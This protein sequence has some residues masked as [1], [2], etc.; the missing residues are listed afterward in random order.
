MRIHWLRRLAPALTA[1]V[2]AAQAQTSPPPQRAASAPAT[3]ASAVQRI[4][5]TGGR[6]GDEEQ[7]RR[8]TAA[9]IVIGRDEIERMGDSNTLE[10]L[11]RL[12][13]ITIP[14]A[15]GRGGSP[16][17][18]GMGGGFTQIL[19]DGERVPP[20]FSLDSIPPEQIERIE[21]LRAPT[22]ETGA[23]A[24]AGTINIVLREGYR[25][26]LNDINVGVQWE[27]GERTPGGSWTRNDAVGDW[28]VNT[29]L[30]LF[31]PQRINESR[32]TRTDIDEAGDQ[33]V[34]ARQS[35]FRSD[36]SRKGLHANAR[37]QWR[38]DAGSSFLL[39]PMV[40]ANEGRTHGVGTVTQSIGSRP[41]EFARSDTTTDGRFTLGRLNLNYNH[42]VGALRLEWRAGVSQGR[43]RG[44]QQRLEFDGQGTLSRT[45]DE[46]TRSSDRNATAGLKA[47]ALL[48]DGHQAVG[49]L[50]VEDNR[51]SD[52]KTTLYD[53]VPQLSEFGAN[54]GARARRW[55]VYAQDEWSINPQW[56]V[57]AGLR[58]EGIRTEG[59]GAQGVV[60]RNTSRVATPLLHAVW[61]PD[62]TKRD[63]VRASLTRSYRAPNTGQL[64]G[65]P[66][67]NR[68]DPAPGPNTELSADSAGNPKLKPEVALGLDLAFERYLADG[69]VLS[70][71]LFHR[72]I[73]DLMRNVV[74]LED[75]SWS[76]GQPRYVARP[77]NI[78]EASSSGIELEAKLRLDQAIDDAPKV[79][80]RANASF[81]RSRVDN[82]PG[83]D[84]RITEQPGATLNVGADYRLRGLPL[85]LGG[86]VNHVPGY[87][88]QLEA[89]RAIQQGRKTAVD[90][91]ALWTFNP[92]TKLRLSIGNAL[93]R[94]YVSSTAVRSA[95]LIETTDSASRSY[96]NTQLRLELKL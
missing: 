93:A 70:A 66:S 47:S 84:N 31:A 62:A 37:L 79:E 39:M 58:V 96:V 16:R 7:R 26:K 41:L 78:G 38:D 80:L 69:G 22:A 88:T 68:T 11:K 35:T 12:P 50:E 73:R 52:A 29:S 65:R 2:L 95:G 44:D 27:G 86:S 49:G 20:G 14:G 17:M 91:Y 18:R 33:T 87:R 63:Q 40:I 75:V 85:A 72:R 1:C 48:G 43:W 42:R 83:P 30:S 67:L 90:A 92:E 56:A 15:P 36:E 21:I 64:I 10:I 59:E 4:E 34:L 13:G 5:V 77:Q 25:K 24:I 94:D 89:D 60:E 71:N 57:H 3:A 46:D 82:V 23:R 6:A 53:G 61:K 81:Y 28:I 55:A 54:L 45:I 32:S 76:P 8:S 19:L 51:R 74:A 9:K